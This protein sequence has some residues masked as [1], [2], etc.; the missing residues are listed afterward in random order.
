MN[1]QNVLRH[2]ADG[3]LE[4]VIE[5]LKGSIARLTAEGELQLTAIPGLALFRREAV[6]EP[7]S[8]MYEP[9]ICMVAQGAKRVLLGGDSF[10]YDAHH[11]PS[12]SSTATF[13]G[14][15]PRSRAG[16]WRPAR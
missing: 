13:P 15:G 12:S 5:A 1:N 4:Q 11:S 16:A 2:L 6:T 10:V 7:I 9:S 14:R 8:G 3:S